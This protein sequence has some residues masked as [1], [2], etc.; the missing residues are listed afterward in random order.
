[1][2]CAAQQNRLGDKI[3]KNEIGVACS[4]YGTE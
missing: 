4:T 3:E 2:I 1:M